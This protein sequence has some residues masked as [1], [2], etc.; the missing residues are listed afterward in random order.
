MI[1]LLVD[2]PANSP[3]FF[4][5]ATVTLLHIPPHWLEL[6]EARLPE[7]SIDAVTLTIRS[8]LGKLKKKIHPI[9]KTPIDLLAG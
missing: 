5:T 7:A 1:R 8:S 9:E 3:D 2:G 6:I 4:I